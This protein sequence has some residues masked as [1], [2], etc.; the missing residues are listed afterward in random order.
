MDV[1]SSRRQSDSH[2]YSSLNIQTQIEHT[3]PTRK[4]GESLS[5]Q[6][7][8]M[9]T[10]DEVESTH[11]SNRSSAVYSFSSVN[12]DSP[13]TPSSMIHEKLPTPSSSSSFYTRMK[14]QLS[15]DSY[16]TAFSKQSD[17][18]DKPNINDDTK[19]IV[20]SIRSFENETD[21]LTWVMERDAGLGLRLN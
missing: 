13:P 3:V 2:R 7:A 1:G 20:A 10:S 21:K 8:K 6:L 17:S 12:R 11:N 4:R 5:D 14:P 18:R 19:S 9:T 16:K 15:L